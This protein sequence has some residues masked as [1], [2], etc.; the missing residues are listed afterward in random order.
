MKDLI[1]NNLKLFERMIDEEVAMFDD[2]RFEFDY[3]SLSY[4]D[5]AYFYFK[6]GALCEGPCLKVNFLDSDDELLMRYN[7]A[8]LTHKAYNSLIKKLE[9]NYSHIL[10]DLVKVIEE[11][12]IDSP[13]NDFEVVNVEYS[14][15]SSTMHPT[16]LINFKLFGCSESLGVD[17][18]TMESFGGSKKY[19]K[20]VVAN[21]ISNVADAM[22]DNVRRGI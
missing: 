16:A 8:K 12:V 10:K 9:F 14:H 20:F 4:C 3:A 7:A 13:I 17:L 6:L 1:M 18:E 2:D 15:L 21:V 11:A 19:A 22:I 5:T